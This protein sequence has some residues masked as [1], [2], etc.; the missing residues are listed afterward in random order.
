MRFTVKLLSNGLV[1]I[2]DTS[3]NRRETL[4]ASVDRPSA[5]SLAVPA[6]AGAASWKVATIDNAI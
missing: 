6:F 3:T 1:E 4:K 2:T 5:A